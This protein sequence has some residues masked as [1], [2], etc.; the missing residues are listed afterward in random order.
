M[1]RLKDQ[2]TISD[3][4][5]MLGRLAYL[6][7]QSPRTARDAIIHHF[8]FTSGQFR[9]FLAAYNKAGDDPLEV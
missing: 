3:Q 5:K 8:N 4:I 1:E 7:E 6:L 2:A 9:A